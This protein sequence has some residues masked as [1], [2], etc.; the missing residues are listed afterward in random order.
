MI[1][2]TLQFQRSAL[3]QMAREGKRAAAMPSSA[4]Q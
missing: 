1:G 4:W 3:N 2:E